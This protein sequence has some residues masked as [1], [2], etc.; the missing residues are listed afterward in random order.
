MSNSLLN[1]EANFRLRIMRHFNH[2]NRLQHEVHYLID[3]SQDRVDDEQAITSGAPIPLWRFTREN[4]Q[5]ENM[6]TGFDTSEDEDE[7]Q[8]MPEI[9]LAPPPPPDEHQPQ[10]DETQLEEDLWRSERLFLISARQ[11]SVANSQYS[12]TL[13]TLSGVP[14]RR[15][16]A[17]RIPS[18]L[19]TNINFK[20]EDENETQ[21]HEHEQQMRQQ[22]QRQLLLQQQQQQ[23]RQQQQQQRNI[24]VQESLNKE[25]EVLR[26][27]LAGL[28]DQIKKR[29]T[30]K[31]LSPLFFDSEAMHVTL[32]LA[33]HQPKTLSKTKVFPGFR[34]LLSMCD[35]CSFRF[36]EQM[37]T[38]L[39]QRQRGA[40][41]N[42]V[43]ANRD[44]PP[45][46]NQ[47]YSVLKRKLGLFGDGKRKKRKLNQPLSELLPSSSSS[48]SLSSSMSASFSLSS[49][50]NISNLETLIS[51][52][53]FTID[54]DIIANGLRTSCFRT[55]SSFELKLPANS[56]TDMP[57]IGPQG[58]L[59]VTQVDTANSASGFFEL[60]NIGG[61][62]Q[63]EVRSRIWSFATFICGLSRSRVL[64]KHPRLTQKLD[65][66]E[67]LLEDANLE[68]RHSG[69]QILRGISVPFNAD[70]VD[71]KNHDLR[72]YQSYNGNTARQSSSCSKVCQQLLDWM[73]ISPFSLF[74]EGYFIDTLTKLESDLANFANFDARITKKSKALYSA[75]QFK[76]NLYE[77]TK[78]FDF[79]ILATTEGD[80]NSNHNRVGRNYSTLFLDDWEEKLSNE[81]IDQMTRN[82]CKTI[83]NIQ[84]NYV[85]LKLRVDLDLA[86]DTLI[87]HLLCHGSSP[88]IEHY[89]RLYGEILTDESLKDELPLNAHF[90]C[91]I[92]KKTG[93]LEIRNTFP[94]FFGSPNLYPNHRCARKEHKSTYLRSLRNL[95]GNLTPTWP[96]S[97]F[98]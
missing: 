72:F 76:S 57:M 46:N 88:S 41:P 50:D 65:L 97:D 15:Q 96:I 56:N 62:L 70:I 3:N 52:P 2:M 16:N 5:L 22:L 60:P 17:I 36:E 59:K 25:A 55:G 68:Y 42:A 43:C 98:V 54:K 39:Q 78:D 21:Q 38:F 69:E 48:S 44:F 18:I 79:H 71:F 85:L 27:Y 26:T 80:T 30:Y 11:Q 91:S 83:A 95:E 53:H 6:E 77:L 47:T 84:L 63:S 82:D 10:R 24:A 14:L 34:S 31:G 4:P 7:E 81:L 89:R 40:I 75:I 87:S 94:E 93:H 33:E 45:Q 64:P 29:K 20:D 8:Y 23:Q 1:H 28:L 90:L 13:R 92:H 73:T 67:I 74:K 37:D 12:E 66:L 32:A 51:Y 61:Q 19:S 58:F 35:D 86:A 49:P 9:N